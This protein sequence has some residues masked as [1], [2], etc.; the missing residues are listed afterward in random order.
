MQKSLNV[1]KYIVL[2]GIF[3]T[4]LLVLIVS[5]SMFF[6][7]ITGKNFSFRILVEIIFGLWLI[8]A[9]FDKNYRP[10]LE[11]KN[12]IIIFVGLFF[13]AL[14]LS[15]IF[16]VNPYRSFWSNYERMEGLIAFLHLLAFFI[17][18]ISMM[19]SE[20]LWKLFF[21]ISL[22][23]SL[24]ISVYGLLQL[25]GS[26]GTHQ[27]SRLDAT[28]GNSAYL[29][30]Y[31]I[32]HIFVALFYLFK[33]KDWYKWLYVPVV[34]LEIII[35]YYTATRGA[36]L[37]FVGG[38]IVAAMLAALFSKDRKIKIAGVAALLS[39]IVLIAGFWLARNSSFIKNSPVLARFATISLK[40]QTTQSRLIVWGMSWEGYKERPLLGWG[41]ENY[42][43]VF[44]KYYKPILWK[45]EPWFD[46]AH[47]V[48]FDRLTQNGII[49][50]LAYLGLFGSVIYY[51]WRRNFSISE[52][53]FLTAMFVA[54]FIHNLFVFDNIISLILFFIFLAYIYTKSLPQFEPVGQNIFDNKNLGAKSA[55]SAIAAIA[56]IFIIY[57]VNIPAI[58][59]SRDLINAF[60]SMQQGDV[61]ASLDN[62]EKSIT[63]GSFG[64][65]EA[66]EHLISFSVS[67]S[68]QQNIDANSKEKI[69]NFASSQMQEQ[70]NRSPT[71][72]R[73]M[74]FL[75]MLYNKVEQYDKAEEILKNAISLS[76]N[77]QALYFEL[78]TSY[79]N[80]KQ[81]DKA[82]EVSKKSFELDEEFLDARQIYAVSLIFNGKTKEA[83]E[84]MKNYG[85]VIVADERFLKAFL[86][87]GDAAKITAIWEK[88]VEANP[89]NIQYRV[90]LAAGYLNLNQRQKAIE[91]L[92][93]AIELDPKFK[94]QG[95]YYINEIRAGRNP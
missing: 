38:L 43:L 33:T 60:R 69:F 29:A 61:S 52:S 90:S 67:V 88:Y 91:Q 6:P 42:N 56:I 87:T 25:T 89:D 37:G 75:G 23:V 21:H 63:R 84:L 46:R 1:L 55:Y 22:F 74:V 66:R 48:F 31:M 93:K 24:I 41:L 71:D 17:V 50:L 65:T 47:N 73:Y 68:S 80:R 5:K 12:L 70:I 53:T 82:V 27:G 26:L 4:P 19:R 7:F 44:N 18:L 10:R 3:L 36:I 79:L 9:I 59:A 35:L 92:Q 86:T 28:L 32:F 8:L 81:Y 77:K 2:A 83:E 13:T 39:I 49:G 40:E 14:I 85:G 16:S 20:K 95:E 11:K 78:A 76:P 45:Q 58:L 94:A 64:S 34:I 62:F 54:Y 30:I 57:F 51:L 72:I 15:T